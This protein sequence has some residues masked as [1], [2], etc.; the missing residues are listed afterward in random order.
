MLRDIKLRLDRLLPL[1]VSELL[2]LSNSGSGM[3][4]VQGMARRVDLSVET[5]DVRLSFLD[6][7]GEVLVVVG[8]GVGSD[9]VSGLQIATAHLR[10][11][12]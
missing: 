11:R 7:R 3:L 9:V 1:L 12:V 5:I 10:R 6:V 8:L 4:L 2:S